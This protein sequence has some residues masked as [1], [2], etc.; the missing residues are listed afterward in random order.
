MSDEPHHT[1]IVT[2]DPEQAD[3]ERF[4]FLVNP[5]LTYRRIVFDLETAHRFLG[6]LTD[7]FVEVAFVQQGSR[8]HAIFNP[9]AGQQG[10][11]P[12]PVASLARNTAATDNPNFLTDP[13]R[14]ILGPVIFASKEGKSVDEATIESVEQAIRAVRNYRLDNAEEYELWRNAVLNRVAES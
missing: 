9:A 5:D 8:F 7:D 12:N 1:P 13:S 10:A 11:E 3:R 14:A 6:G 4:G 2:I